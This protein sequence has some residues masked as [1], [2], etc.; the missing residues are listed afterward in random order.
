MRALLLAVFVVVSGSSQG[1]ADDAAPAPQASTPAKL[2]PEQRAERIQALQAAKILI[3]YQAGKIQ[4][5]PEQVQ[6]Y[7]ATLH[8]YTVAHPGSKS[9]KG[10][11]FVLSN[12]PLRNLAAGY[13]AYSGKPVTITDRAGA[14]LVSLRASGPANAD[15][16]MQLDQ[17]LKAQGFVVT[18]TDTGTTIDLP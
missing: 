10:A 11:V 8:A 16:I 17:A 15:V 12:S 7:R 1:F 9:R 3:Q 14:K 5:T 13:R 6:E 2:T 18:H 4:L